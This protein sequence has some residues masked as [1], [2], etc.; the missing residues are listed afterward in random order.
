MAETEFYKYSFDISDLQ[1]ISVR[2]GTHF[3]RG[4]AIGAVP[5]FL[6]AFFL[7]GN[8][9]DMGGGRSKEFKYGWAMLGGLAMAVPT[10]LVGGLVGLFF[11]KYTDYDVSKI[12]QSQ[13]N[14]YLR[15]LFNEY[16]F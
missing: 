11:P 9:G 12:K 10:G 3:W 1:K 8:F 2:N 6:M 16:K 14:K 4:A 13:K 15:K 7:V 5:G